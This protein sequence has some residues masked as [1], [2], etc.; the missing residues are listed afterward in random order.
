MSCFR[1]STEVSREIERKLRL[2]GSEL[3]AKDF[4][5]SVQFFYQQLDSAD[6]KHSYDKDIPVFTVVTVGEEQFMVSEVEDQIVIKTPSLKVP[7]TN[8][9]I[10]GID[11][12]LFERMN[13]F[14]SNRKTTKRIMYHFKHFRSDGSDVLLG[15]DVVVFQKGIDPKLFALELNS[16]FVKSLSVNMAFS[17]PRELSGSS[18]LAFWIFQYAKQTERVF[19]PTHAPM[20]VEFRD[21]MFA[22]DI[23]L[24]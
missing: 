7:T 5:T 20:E 23:L 14:S 3:V 21:C 19:P 24:A 12:K 18:Q 1:I 13:V 15:D 9:D 2:S 6:S 10:T 22:K 17:R 16:G 8:V 11:P 4:V